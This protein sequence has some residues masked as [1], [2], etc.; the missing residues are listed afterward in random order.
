M[1]R[2]YVL[3]VCLFNLLLGL[4]STAQTTKSTK[5]TSSTSKSGTATTKKKAVCILTNVYKPAMTYGTLT[6]QDGNIYKTV[7]IA[8]QEWM[9]EN[10]KASHYRNG[11]AITLV[12]GSK[13][14][15]ALSTGATAWY[16]NDSSANNCAYGKLYN[17]Y[18]VADER[19][20][21]PKGWHVPSD[22]DWTTLEGNLNGPNTA[23]GKLKSAGTQF[24]SSVNEGGDNSSGFSALPGGNRFGNGPFFDIGTSGYWWTSSESGADEAWFRGMINKVAMTDRNAY[25]RKSGFSVRCVKD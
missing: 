18:A 19:M 25:D 20:L 3:T 2:K 10:L 6:D 24:W 16:N 13:E 8:S 14:W 7:R 17:W 12:T 1:T 4:C 21:C 23:G 5:P 15:S 11:T 9:A 22:D